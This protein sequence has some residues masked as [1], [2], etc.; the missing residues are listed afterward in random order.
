M[1][2]KAELEDWAEGVKAFDAL[3]YDGAL[4]AFETIATT[5]KIHFNIAQIFL[6]VGALRDAGMVTILSFVNMHLGS[7]ARRTI[8][9]GA[10][11]RAIGCDSFL[12]VAYFQRGVCCY[13]AGMANEAIDDFT[14]ALKHFRGN[15][16]IDYTQL[17]L[18]YRLYTCEVNYNLGLAWASLGVEAKAWTE[19]DTAFQ[20][21]PDSDEF[22]IIG[23]ALRLGKRAPD[24]LPPFEVPRDCVYRPAEDKM[25]NA[26]KV[27]FLGS[28]KV[29]ASVKAS[30]NY[31]GFSGSR[32][33]QA[34]L[35]RSRSQSA[36]AVDNQTLQRTRSESSIPNRQPSPYSTLPRGGG[37]VRRGNTVPQEYAKAKS[38]LSRSPTSEPSLTR[39]LSRNDLPTTRKPRKQSL[40]NNSD[41]MIDSGY[42]DPMPVNVPITIPSRKS[43]VSTNSSD[44]RRDRENGSGGL[45][46]MGGLGASLPR[47]NSQKSSKPQIKVKCHFTDTRI[48]LVPTNVTFE[49]LV[50]RVQDKFKQDQ[51]L[52]LKYKDEDEEMVLMTDQEDLEVAIACAGIEYYGNSD[53]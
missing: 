50:Y 15:T 34:T 39:S 37:E 3:D 24:Y 27:D 41:P 47:T 30:D 18:K 28:A 5:A 38:P 21:R 19:F 23:E 48:I 7:V 51:P 10:L 4:R 53:G 22:K 26:A 32:I 1:A 14:K 45:G 49:E 13:N 43:S 20:N 44:G 16:Y 17:G 25:K 42:H 6:N 12:A 29:V 2:L 52:K 11:T 46:N 33:K 36:G 31:A 35:Q 8:L 9:I 40:G